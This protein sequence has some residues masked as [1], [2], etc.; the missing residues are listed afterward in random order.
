MPPRKA[1]QAATTANTT[2]P[3]GNACASP[4]IHLAR[5]IVGGLGVEH[6]VDVRF[7]EREVGSCG[8]LSLG[9]L[10]GIRLLKSVHK[11]CLPCDR[12]GGCGQEG[13]D[14]GSRAFCGR[15]AKSPFEVLAERQ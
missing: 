7:E 10:D 13:S 3:W 1:S 11:S 12:H 2:A 15:E 6:K 8:E 14:V 4:N 9:K 5:V